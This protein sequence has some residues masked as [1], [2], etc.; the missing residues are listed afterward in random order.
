VATQII[1]AVVGLGLLVER[2]GGGGVVWELFAGIAI[3]SLLV[4]GFYAAQR[5]GLFFAL[6]RALEGI[7]G[8]PG[9]F[10]IRGGAEDLDRLVRKLYRRQRAF[11]AA[12]FFHLAAWMLGAG[13][14][15][16]ALYFLGAPVTWADAIILESLGMAV[17]AAAFAV[18]GALGVQEGGFILLGPLVGLTPDTALALSLVKRVR[19]LVLGIPGLIAWQITEGWNLFRRQTEP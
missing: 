11:W 15:W 2:G 5:A 8:D 9:R 6:S 4:G 14:V 3:F 19:E 10:S 16:L 13:E 1:F 17:R 18:P 12:C 7:V